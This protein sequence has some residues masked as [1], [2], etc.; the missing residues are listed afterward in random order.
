M[1]RCMEEVYGLPERLYRSPVEIRRE[2]DG[3]RSGI[4]RIN[5]GLNVRSLLLD[6]YEPEGDESPEE[7]VA[8][9]TSAL[10]AAEEAIMEL[11]GL[12][13]ELEMLEEELR[14]VRCEMGM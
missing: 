2:M 11:N 13:G 3:V 7:L 12:Y 14:V 8:A 6:I 9:L 10:D 4:E 5:E 1:H